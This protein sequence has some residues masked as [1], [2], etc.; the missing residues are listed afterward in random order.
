MA[1]QRRIDRVLAE[2]YLDGLAERSTE[3]L[4]AMREEC[5]LEESGISYARRILQGKLDIVRAEA[6]RRRDAG[7][8]SAASLLSGLPGILGG[9]DAHSGGPAVRATRFRVPPEVQHH[10]RGVDEIADDTVLARIRERSDEELHELVASMSEKEQQ[11]SR[12]RRALLDRIDT[13]QQEITDRYKSGAADI[14]E[15]LSGPS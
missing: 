6:V 15:L 11:L 8:S 4:R 7:S 1:G 3:Q 13:L 9:D 12:T 14:S 2:D 10:R 5:E